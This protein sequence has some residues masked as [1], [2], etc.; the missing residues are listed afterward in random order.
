MLRLNILKT[1]ECTI[2]ITCIQFLG[3]VN[4]LGL[5]QPQLHKTLLCLIQNLVHLPYYKCETSDHHHSL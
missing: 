2:N 5:V 3:H 4:V 1:Q